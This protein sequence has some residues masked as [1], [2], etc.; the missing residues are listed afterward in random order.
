VTVGFVRRRLLRRPPLFCG[1]AARLRPAVAC[2][3]ECPRTRMDRHKFKAARLA[4]NMSQGALAKAVRLSPSEISR[5]EC[6]YRDIR[7]DEAVALAA[8]L[9]LVPASTSAPVATVAPVAVIPPTVSSVVAAPTSPVGTNLDDPTNFT[10]L[11]DVGILEHGAVSPAAHRDRL[12]AALARTT[13]I[14][15]TSRVRATVW[16]EW[17]QFERKIQEALRPV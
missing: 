11:P 6:G 8:A 14:L 17:R 4:Q 1:V 13:K 12:V 7:P 16:R 9:G 10:E 2:R 3:Y 15:H 5:I